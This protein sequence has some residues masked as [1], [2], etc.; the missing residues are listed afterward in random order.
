MS[1]RLGTAALALS[2]ALAAC[3]A[4]RVV[5]L[6]RSADPSWGLFLVGDDIRQGCAAGASDRFRLVL[7]ADHLQRLRAFDVRADE[8]GATV[9]TRLIRTA[10][11][12][13]RDAHAL[14]ATGEGAESIRIDAV[15]FARLVDRLGRT[16]GFRPPPAGARLPSGGYYWLVSGCR[17]GAYFLTVYDYPSDRFVET[18]WPGADPAG[19]AAPGPGA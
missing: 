10:D 16:G 18:A 15:Q 12:R 11:M 7:N 8:E 6:P 19:A 2:A 5:D 14:L 1:R 17:R 9:E 3:A 4:P 13:A